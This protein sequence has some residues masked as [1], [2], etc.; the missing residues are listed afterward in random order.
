MLPAALT[1][2]F[3]YHAGVTGPLL[4]LL[5]AAALAAEPATLD[6]AEADARMAAAR[7]ALKEHKVGAAAAALDR[8]LELPLDVPR[9][10]DAARLYE[11]ARDLCGSARAAERLTKAD[12]DQAGTWVAF[13]DAAAYCGRTDDAR[14]AL[15]EAFKR[16]HGRDDLDQGAYLGLYMDDYRRSLRASDEYVK[17]APDDLWH[18]LQRAA[19][20]AGAGESKIFEEALARASAL[21]DERGD[22]AAA[23]WRAIAVRGDYQRA[24][25]I[26]QWAP[27]TPFA[28]GSASARMME[29]RRAVGLRALAEAEKTAGETPG[30]LA[31]LAMIHRALGDEATADRLSAGEPPADGGDFDYWHEQARRLARSNDASKA[32]EAARRAA[33]LAGDDPALLKRAARLIDELGGCGAGELYDSVLAK[34]P[35]DH[36]ARAAR[37]AVAAR[38]S[39][40]AQALAAARRT[41]AA[42]GAP[43]ASRAMAARILLELGDPGAL[44]AFEELHKSSPTAAAL[45]M[46]LADARARFGDAASALEAAA[47]A[48]SLGGD[49]SVSRRVSALYAR[50]GD[51][52]AVNI[53]DKLVARSPDDPFPLLD[54]ASASLRCGDA[55]GARASV[56]AALKL[57]R[58]EREAVLRAS[59]VLADLRD[60][61]AVGILEAAVKERPADAELAIA[62]AEA[63]AR[64]G[65]LA[66][67]VAAARKIAELSPAGAASA[68]R[69][70]GLYAG[71][72][73]PEKGCPGRA[74]VLAALK[75]SSESSDHEVLRLAARAYQ[76]LG[77]TKESVRALERLAK[78]APR[79]AAAL[80]D[81]GVALFLDGRAADAAKAFERALAVEPG[82]A[83]AALSLSSV[84]AGLGRP[85]AARRVLETAAEKADEEGRKRLIAAKAELSGPSPTPR[86]SAP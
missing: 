10:R 80:S 86:R 44:P 63:R 26:L 35:E 58:G 27:R 46:D 11:D 7:A 36:D 81:L 55:S 5:A 4:S 34:A 49:P 40:P 83:D 31:R 41:L 64:F 67:T 75:D 30:L 79:D 2:N 28:R 23:R 54:R 71:A 82:R 53:Y 72:S 12:P 62:L 47:K 52:G 45:A 59:R 78:L 66:E 60:P 73:C 39:D 6:A 74:E 85:D 15:D 32:A 1:L 51:C 65:G 38:C 42:P 24:R 18:W 57:A 56:D 16:T 48:Q 19:A 68:R 3:P 13:A 8:A 20:A 22:A 33:A 43:V 84:Y 21:V 76:R 9:L 77:A 17:L 69:V 70:A 50:V 25:W 14:A 61:L 37:A 29:R